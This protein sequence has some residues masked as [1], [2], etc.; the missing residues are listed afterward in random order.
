MK[1]DELLHKWINKT[2]SNEELA[3][4]KQRPE[5]D[6]LVEIY[7]NTEHL[8]APSFDEDKM[9]T[10]ILNE[11]KT[12]N[13][14][15]DEGKRV[16]LSNW[17]K[18]AAAAALL[19]FGLAWFLRSNA[20]SPSLGGYATVSGEKIDGKLPD[21]STFVL[22][23]ES[24][25]DYKEYNWHKDRRIGLEGEAFFSVKKGSKFTVITPNGSV[26]VLGTK[27]NV[28]SRGKTLEVSCQEGKV[29]VLTKDG[30][31]IDQLNPTDAI[32]IVDNQVNDKWKF[33][34]TEKASWVDGIS[35]FKKVPLVVVLDELE[36]QYEIEIKR[37]DIDTNEILSCNFQHEN[38]ELALKTTLGPLK[39]QHNINNSKVIVLQKE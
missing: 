2:I 22:N 38:L 6:S 23:A 13:V 11:K 10:D 17:M 16:F 33:Q 36:R 29:A 27:F 20:V 7:K 5:Y 35:K 12:P 1:N 34:A 26:Q 4:F 30:K 39:V 21:G 25:L 15:T 19:L 31:E 32:R 8:S 24:D 9:L 3:V 18:Y 37:N 14:K 28:R